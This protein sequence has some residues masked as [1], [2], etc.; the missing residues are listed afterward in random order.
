MRF[1]KSLCISSAKASKNILV[2]IAIFFYNYVLIKS[3]KKLN[4]YISAVKVNALMEM[5]FNGTHFISS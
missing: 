5:Y 3:E 1:L 4:I 2:K